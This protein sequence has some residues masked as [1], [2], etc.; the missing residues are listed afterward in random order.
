MVF[1][2]AHAPQGWAINNQN[3]SGRKRSECV[4]LC[5]LVGF[6]VPHKTGGVM[7]MNAL[8]ASF[9]FAW[10]RGFYIYMMLAKIVHPTRIDFALHRASIKGQ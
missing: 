5:V 3:M 10:L 4:C 8:C 7:M 1:Q 6:D 9:F 2:C